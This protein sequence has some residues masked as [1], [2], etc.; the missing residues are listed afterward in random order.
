MVTGLAGYLR[1]RGIKDLTFVGLATDYCVAW[2]ALD[3]VKEGFI[4][5][6]I[7]SACRAID[8]D[9]SLTAALNNMRAAGVMLKD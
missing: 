3:A 9:G 6:V 1:E 5:T 4:T 2:S 8:I 7:L